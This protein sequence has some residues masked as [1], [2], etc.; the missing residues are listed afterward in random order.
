MSA[1][2]HESWSPLR[3]DYDYRAAIED[4]LASAPPD[5]DLAELGRAAAKRTRDYVGSPEFT[6]DAIESVRDSIRRMREQTGDLEAGQRAKAE[7]AVEANEEWIE[8][9]EKRR[10]AL[11]EGDLDTVAAEKQVQQVIDRELDMLELMQ[12]IQASTAASAATLGALREAKRSADQ[13]QDKQD[14]FNKAMAIVALVLAFGSFG[15]P[16]VQEY[17][18]KDPPPKQNFV[19]VL[20]SDLTVPPLLRRLGP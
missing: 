19:V 15:M 14:G 17:V 5:F 10:R 4:Y 16:F 11:A 18:W 20:G 6:Q 1:K 3:F 12:S 2:E 8:A 7:R 13:K 9:A